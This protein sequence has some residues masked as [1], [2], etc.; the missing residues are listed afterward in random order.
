MLP[1]S[2]RSALNGVNPEIGILNK[3]SVHLTLYPHASLLIYSGCMCA[4]FCVRVSVR[5]H[6][7]RVAL[8]STC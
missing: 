3:G 8:A 7:L 4:C 5:V 6:V 2:L 1:Y